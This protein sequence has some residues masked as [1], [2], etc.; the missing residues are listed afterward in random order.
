M[1]RWEDNTQ[2]TQ[3][4]NW[5]QY[6]ILH[7]RSTDFFIAALI[8]QRGKGTKDKNSKTIEDQNK[9]LIGFSEKHRTSCCQGDGL[10]LFL[11]KSDFCENEKETVK[12]TI[13]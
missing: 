6:S 3:H 1:P 11:L 5:M 8:Q 13:V 9:V 10:F 2:Q 7:G 4:H 12:K